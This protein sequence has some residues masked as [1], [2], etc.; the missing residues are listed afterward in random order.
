M[1]DIAAIVFVYHMTKPLQSFLL[2]NVSDFI[3]YSNFS[4]Y[5]VH[6]DAIHARNSHSSPKAIVLKYTQFFVIFLLETLSLLNLYGYR[7]NWCRKEPWLLLKDFI[8]SIFF[9]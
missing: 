1:V 7:D 3:G 2:D 8:V 4:P 5:D 9:L 6:F